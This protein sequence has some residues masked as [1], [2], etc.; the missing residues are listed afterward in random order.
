MRW[1]AYQTSPEP[2]QGRFPP[3]AIREVQ[4]PQVAFIGC[5]GGAQERAQEI[6]RRW[7][8]HADLLTACEWLLWLL[9]EEQ[10]DDTVRW[11]RGEYK[12]WGDPVVIVQKAKAAIAEAKGE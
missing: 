7:N 12:D 8:A 1:V 11:L 9:A 10:A 2:G 6:A 3:W 4:G 5:Q